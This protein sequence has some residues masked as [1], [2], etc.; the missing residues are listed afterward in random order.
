MLLFSAVATAF[1]LGCPAKSAA[2]TLLKGYIVF[3]V[4]LDPRS[5]S[6]CKRQTVAVSL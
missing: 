2:V 4:R 5:H 6:Q 1:A 3:S